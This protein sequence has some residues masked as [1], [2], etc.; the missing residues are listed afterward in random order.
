MKKV[1]LLLTIIIIAYGC[2]SNDPVEL[3]KYI[4]TKWTANDDISKLVYGGVCTTTIEFLTESTCQEINVRSGSASFPGT[5]LVNGTCKINGDSV[6]WTTK[7]GTIKGK[8]TGSVLKTTMGTLAGG[9]RV[10]TKQ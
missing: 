7:T 10:Y 9:F 4:G 8:I 2:Q 5:Y 1:I 3:S 6:S